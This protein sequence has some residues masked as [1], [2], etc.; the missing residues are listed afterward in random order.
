MTYQ[1]S[2]SSNRYS[3]KKIGVL[4]KDISEVIAVYP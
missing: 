1:E 2:L 3:L 4:N